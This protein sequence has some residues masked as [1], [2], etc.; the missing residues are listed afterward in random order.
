MEVIDPSSDL[1]FDPTNASP[2]GRLISF[3]LIKRW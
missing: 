3:E 1:G 2:L